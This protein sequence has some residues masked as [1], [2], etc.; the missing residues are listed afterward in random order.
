MEQV[1]QVAAC[2]S[3]PEFL[4]VKS[5]VAKM[6]DMIEEAGRKSDNLKLVV[7]SELAT[8]GYVV[9]PRERTDYEY[10]DA[11]QRAAETVDGPTVTA[12]RNL[13][14]S[15]HVFLA[16]G[17]VE[18]DAHMSGVSYNSVILIDDDGQVVAVHRKCHISPS[19]FSYFRSGSTPTV[20]STPLGRLGLSICY[21]FWFPEFIRHQVVNLGCELHVNVTANVKDFALGSTHFP[22]VRAAENSVY[23]VSTNRVG[24]DE[25][26]QYE[27]VGYSSIVSPDGRVLAS[28]EGEEA[29]IVAEVDMD[30]VKRVRSRVPVLKDFK[31][32][33]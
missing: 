29:V 23:V 27:F 13:A 33:P 32:W 21:D 28:A 11:F 8:T 19:E 3:S 10:R 20:A 26:S 7:F 22:I 25:P 17:F 2:Q 16:T 15:N 31:N 1:Y 5:N 6:G 24:R 9:F 30:E 12:L 18:A 14:R 4:D